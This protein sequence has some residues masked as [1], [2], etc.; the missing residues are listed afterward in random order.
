MR[1]ISRWTGRVSSEWRRLWRARRRIQSWRALRH[2]SWQTLALCRLLRGRSEARSSLSRSTSHY[3]TE[4][5]AWAVAN[6][7]RRLCG[8]RRTTDVRRAASRLQLMAQSAD[9]VFISTEWST[10]T[11]DYRQCLGAFVGRTVS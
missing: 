10:S 6:A 9:L 7:R 11:I 4:Q 5:I 8:V 2:V 3:A 1:T